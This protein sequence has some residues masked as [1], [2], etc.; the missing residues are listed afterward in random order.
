MNY[1]FI[2]HTAF[3]YAGNLL[4]SHTHCHSSVTTHPYMDRV[5]V[6]L[7]YYLLST[8]AYDEI[9]VADPGGDC[10]RLEEKLEEAAEKDTLFKP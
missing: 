4:R 9:F 8:I 3:N 2:Y 6:M 5:V 1:C 7:R 10:S